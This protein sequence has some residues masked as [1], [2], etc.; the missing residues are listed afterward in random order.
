MN[1]YKIILFDFLSWCKQYFSKCMYPETIMR[2][3]IYGQNIRTKIDQTI[4]VSLP[5][6]DLDIKVKFPELLG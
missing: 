4:V 5:T 2:F 1:E 3:T 6:I